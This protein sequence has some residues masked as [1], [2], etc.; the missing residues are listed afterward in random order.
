MSKLKKGPKSLHLGTMHLSPPVFQ[1]ANGNKNVQKTG[2]L[3]TI[4]IRKD[5]R[6]RSRPSPETH[7]HIPDNLHVFSCTS[8]HNDGV[9]SLI[10][11]TAAV[12]TS[13]NSVTTGGQ[14]TQS[15]Q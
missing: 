6:S 1:E 9:L 7:P 15:G 4:S 13:G 12:E 10:T 5:P 11:G 2:S 8:F 14:L 3:H